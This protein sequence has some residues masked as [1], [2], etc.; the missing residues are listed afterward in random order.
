MP[1][2]G[3]HS[4]ADEAPLF[5]VEVS[6]SG[7]VRFTLPEP[8]QGDV[9]GEFLWVSSLGRGLGANDVGLDRGQLGQPR[10]VRFRRVGERVLLEAENLAYRATG[11]GPDEA[12]A[13][14]QS[15]ATSVLWSGEVASRSS[16]SVTFDA[17][18]LIVRDAHGVA[19]SLRRAGQG[20]F[21]RA[22]E[23]SGVQPELCVALP[24]NV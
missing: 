9:L 18:S 13:T 7:E 24:H 6:E 15:F 14:E 2:D 4:G 12:R 23:R 21:T 1:A 22:E 10:V 3:R 20:D 11:A 8:E 16:R 17:S 19:A 5:D